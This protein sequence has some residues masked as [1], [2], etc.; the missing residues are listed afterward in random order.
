MLNSAAERKG[1]V[2]GEFQFY[3]I[4]KLN[5]EGQ[6]GTQSSPLSRNKIFALLGLGKGQR[7]HFLDKEITNLVLF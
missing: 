2:G 5:Q 6:G 1:K 7:W 3:H 4:L